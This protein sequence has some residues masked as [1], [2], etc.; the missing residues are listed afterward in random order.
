MSKTGFA[1]T[2]DIRKMSTENFLFSYLCL[3]LTG[4]LKSI[5]DVQIG[6]L[7]GFIGMTDESDRDPSLMTC[8]WQMDLAYH[9]DGTCMPE[10]ILSSDLGCN[11][12]DGGINL[13]CVLSLEQSILAFD[14]RAVLISTLSSIR[15][16][17][18]VQ[19]SVSDV[20][21]FCIMCRDKLSFG[22]R[23]CTC[24]SF[25]SLYHWK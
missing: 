13:Q 21:N 6:Y 14:G 17:R 5:H 1:T 7:K 22:L 8:E 9:D 10:E 23:S 16:N 3:L 15:S 4:C 19:I 24:S 20:R 18:P 2:L 12:T 11:L 25:F